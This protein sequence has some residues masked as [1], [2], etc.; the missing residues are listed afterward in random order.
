M[1]QRLQEQA[2]ALS[3]EKQKL[4]AEAQRTDRRSKA[5]DSLD[6]HLEKLKG[7]LEQR[8]QEVEV[9][10]GGVAPP[11]CNLWLSIVPRL[12]RW[13]DGDTCTTPCMALV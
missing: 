9:S 13:C 8:Q 4:A 6:A 7:D 3:L 2:N 10:G 12:T 5:L 1:A 11:H